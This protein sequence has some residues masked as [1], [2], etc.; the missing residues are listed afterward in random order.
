M[1]RLGPGNL[2][3]TALQSRVHCNP[4]PSNVS[5]THPLGL[6]IQAYLEDSKGAEAHVAEQAGWPPCL[7]SGLR[8]F[9]PERQVHKFAYNAERP[10]LKFFGQ[11]AK[12]YLVFR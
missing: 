2:P 4:W 10:D 3:D 9:E 12:C 1:T 11:L 6:Q 5:L 8:V 7:S